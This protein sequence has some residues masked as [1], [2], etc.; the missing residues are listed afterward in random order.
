MAADHVYWEYWGKSAPALSLKLEHYP[1]W[2][3]PVLYFFDVAAEE[4]HARL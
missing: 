1:G 4:M 2:H 3:S